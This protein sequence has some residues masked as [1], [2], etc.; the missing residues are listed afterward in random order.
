MNNS[1]YRQDLDLLKGF[2]IIVVVLYHASIIQSGYLGVD[3]FF[4][5]NGFLIIPSLCRNIAQSKGV[6]YYFSFLEKRLMRLWP[7]II[8]A[9]I[10][11]FLIGYCIGMLPDDFENLNET[12][13]AS[14]LMSNNLLSAITIRDYWAVRTNFQPLM[15]LWYVGI[16]FEFYVVT[17]LFLYLAKFCAKKIGFNLNYSFI[18]VLLILSVLSLAIYLDPSISDASRFYHLHSRYYEMGLSGV[19]AIYFKNNE[20]KLSSI[21]A[22]YC[23]LVF[24]IL[25]LFC[26]TISLFDSDYLGKGIKIRPI[27]APKNIE[28]YFL[29]I[30]RKYLLLLVVAISIILVNLNGSK[31]LGKLCSANNPICFLGKMSFSIY[32]WHQILLAFER[33]FFSNK[34]NFYYI[35]IFLIVTICISLVTY[36]LVEQRIKPNSKNLIICAVFSLIVSSVSYYYYSNAGVTRD[37]P[38]LGVTVKEA[39]KKMH[40]KYLTSTYNKYNKGFFDTGRYNIC[41]I[42]N[43]FMS[44]F[45]NI[46]NESNYADSVNIIMARYF[47]RIS[48][49]IIRQSDYVFIF[50]DPDSIPSFIRENIESSRIFGIGTKNFGD[51]NGVI[52]RQRHNKQYFNLSFK[53]HEEYRELND[54]WKKKWGK[55]YIDLFKLC[56]LPNGETRIFTPEHKYMSQDCYHLTQPAARFF[57]DR[58]EWSTII[59]SKRTINRK[60][61]YP[62]V[63]SKVHQ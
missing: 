6:S 56:L 47:N 61:V 24:F 16:L 39:T 10:V 48:P 43:S 14:N 17:P 1:L 26:L 4:V 18:A 23:Y 15:H 57:A 21:N 9:S 30:N 51:S 28:T 55:N 8:I 62:L 12:I 42:G 44:D 7:L 36:Y 60:T 54:L 20:G 45:V 37:V 40:S 5:I 52:Y 35:E 59:N 46:L 34:V 13:V 27:G 31:W 38:E 22:K 25:L 29:F 11:C 3:L 58:I 33:Y 50:N 32:I 41:T 2:A 49:D 19:A 63:R 53:P